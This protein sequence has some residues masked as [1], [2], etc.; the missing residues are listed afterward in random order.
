[1]NRRLVAIVAA[2]I[3]LG[4]AIWG[5]IAWWQRPASDTAAVQP[6]PPT[7]LDEQPAGADIVTV[8]QTGEGP[9]PNEGAT[10]MKDRVAVLGLLNK[11]NG[12]AREVTLKPGGAIRIGDVVMRLRACEQTAPW[13]VDHYTGAFVQLDV[14]GI[15]RHW[16][17]AFSGWLYKERPGLNVVQHPIYDVWTKSCTMSFP[18][19]VPEEETVD[20]NAAAPR[21]SRP[22]SP[23]RPAAAASGTPPRPTAP[24]NA[25]DSSDR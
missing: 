9:D 8:D 18:D 24:S 5:G 6:L 3:V 11:R 7:A 14:R 12:E 20:G 23:A 25:S 4:A 19:T 22:K 13:E 1:M 17:R 15:D 2:V 21:S 16:R 10:P